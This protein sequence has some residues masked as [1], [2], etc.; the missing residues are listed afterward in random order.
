MPGS[1]KAKKK[2]QWHLCLF[3]SVVVFTNLAVNIYI[4]SA[5]HA[6]ICAL[7]MTCSIHHH[8]SKSIN[9]HHRLDDWRPPQTYSKYLKVIE[10]LTRILVQHTIHPWQVGLDS[11]KKDYLALLLFAIFDV[12]TKRTN[13]LLSLSLCICCHDYYDVFLCRR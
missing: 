7:S 1:K 11:K 3:F 8:Q 10:R 4:P 13:N 5:T 2:K 6:A 9:I 12:R